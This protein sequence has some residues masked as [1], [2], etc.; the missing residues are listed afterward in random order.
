MVESLSSPITQAPAIRA[1]R[2]DVMN[3]DKFK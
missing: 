2:N 3:L 1:H